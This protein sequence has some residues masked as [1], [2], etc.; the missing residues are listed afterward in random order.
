LLHIEASPSAEDIWTFVFFR[1]LEQ[2]SKGDGEK[3]HLER[4]I[5]R[6]I[7]N[8]PLCVPCNSYSLQKVQAFMSLG[9]LR[10]ESKIMFV[11]TMMFLE[12]NI[13][14][15]QCILSYILMIRMFLFAIKYISCAWF[16]KSKWSTGELPSPVNL[17]RE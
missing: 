12:T 4:G 9:K 2:W 8:V 10:I 13:K 17:D 14:W 15:L 5:T 7:G 6:K 11:M 3:F 16:A 1:D